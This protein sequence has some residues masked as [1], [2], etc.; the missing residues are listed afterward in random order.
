MKQVIKKAGRLVS[1]ALILVML[2]SVTVFGSE[3]LEITKTYPKNGAVNTTKDNMCVKVYFNNPVGNKASAENNKDKFKFTD[4]T[5]K[6]FPA[7]IFYDEK[8]PHYALILIDTNKVKTTGKGKY[9]IKDDKKYTCTIS[10]NFIDNKGNKLGK[11]VK[12]Q[13]ST[14][15]QGRGTMI[16]MVMMALMFG[17]MFYFTI[18]Q[19]RKQKEEENK[20]DK[21]EPFNPYKEAKRTG[22]TVEEVTR[23][24]QKEMEKKRADK[25]E[26]QKAV[27][28]ASK[29][30]VH[31]VK[32]PRPI[33]A[34]GCTYKTG[35]KA[36]AEQ[37]KAEEARR[38][39]E[40][41]ATDYGKKT[42]NNK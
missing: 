39:A 35:R 12:I 25:K 14:M 6:K 8:D 20:E 29:A 33:S 40:L 27:E 42:K 37:K 23:I 17:G 34:A 41:K 24:H 22:K 7:M 36:I 9:V 19:Q 10:K 2:A 21:E 13:F 31:R 32:G 18:R 3:T 11:D 28:E 38:K 30:G 16:Y 15:N 4:K 1:I 26:A 5:G